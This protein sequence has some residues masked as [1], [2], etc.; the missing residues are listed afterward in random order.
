VITADQCQSW[1]RK[2][3]RKEKIYEDSFLCAGWEEGGR[4]S[5]QGDS[6]NKHKYLINTFI[7]NILNKQNIN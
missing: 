2:A 1:Y 3:G 4:D 7:K 6:G 5:C